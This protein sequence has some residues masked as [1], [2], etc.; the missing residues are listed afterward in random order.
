MNFNE[1]LDAVRVAVQNRIP[2]LIEGKPG[3][4]KSTIPVMIAKELEMWHALH[5]CALGNDTDIL[6]LPGTEPSREGV[7]WRKI[8][9]FA[10]VMKSTTPGILGLEDLSHAGKET[11][12]AIFPMIHPGERRLGDEKLPEGVTIVATGNRIVDTGSGARAL[13]T[14]L[15]DRFGVVLQLDDDYKITF[16]YLRKVHAASEAAMAVLDSVGAARQDAIARIS[17]RR[18]DLVCSWVTAAYDSGL[19]GEVCEGGALDV[20]AAGIPIASL[21]DGA[22]IAKF[23]REVAKAAIY[24]T[25]KPKVPARILHKLPIAS[26]RTVRSMTNRPLDAAVASRIVSWCGGVNVE[27][28]IQAVNSVE[29]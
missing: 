17:P 18:W 24:S 1:V 27:E 21:I 12:A 11:Q 10:E 19:P 22:T 13:L 7:V 16:E 28:L 23:A 25:G 5:N 3:G 8:G 20:K 29:L 6:G 9:V 14:V 4:G 2:T 15:R 26:G